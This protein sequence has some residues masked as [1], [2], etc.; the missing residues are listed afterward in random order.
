M[1]QAP[2]YTGSCLCGAVT[3]A[4]A[5]EPRVT[6]ACHCSKCRKATGSAFATWTLVP[7]DSFAFSSGSEHVAEY[8]SSDHGRRLFC[9]HCGAT[10]GN[11]TSK[12]PRFFHLATG[13][14]DH[15]PAL[16]IA[17]HVHAASKAPWYQIKD[18]L[19]QHDEEP[20]QS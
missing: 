9:R 11:F 6:V 14:L 5:A 10:L 20:R 13:T 15:A 16:E 7:K 17:F 19:P 12:R 3:Y 2:E 18:N 8:A 4:F 1:S